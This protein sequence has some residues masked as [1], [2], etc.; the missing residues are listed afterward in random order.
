MDYILS[1]G[2]W[3]EEIASEA[4]EEFEA[5]QSGYADG[6]VRFMPSGQVSELH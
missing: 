3:F 5:N 6:F 2:V 4:L 1:D